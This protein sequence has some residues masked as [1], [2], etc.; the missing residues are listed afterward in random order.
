MLP[1]TSENAIVSHATHA[2]MPVS[3]RQR[4]IRLARTRFSVF[5]GQA[6]GLG[7]RD[8]MMGD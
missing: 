2:V 5:D 6:Q 8:S 4:I 3:Y 7:F 1:V